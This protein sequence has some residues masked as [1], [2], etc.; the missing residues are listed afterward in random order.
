MNETVTGAAAMALSLRPDLIGRDEADAQLLATSSDSS[1]VFARAAD[2]T[3]MVMRLDDV[4]TRAVLHDV[5]GWIARRVDFQAHVDSDRRLA[6]EPFPIPVPRIRAAD[7]SRRT[8]EYD[9]PGGIRLGDLLGRGGELAALGIDAE[10]VAADLLDRTLEAIFERKLFI[11]TLHPADL[12]ITGCDQVALGVPVVVAGIDETIAGYALRIY[13]AVRDGS[14][15]RAAS[16]I[17]D[18]LEGDDASN[19]ADFRRELTALL[20]A[21]IAGDTASEVA[22]S[23]FVV[24]ETI[25]EVLRLARRHGLSL[26]RLTLGVVLNILTV[27]RIARLLGAKTSLLDIGRDFFEELLL[28]RAAGLLGSDLTGAAADMLALARNLPGDL[29]SILTD[30]ADERFR[31][32]VVTTDSAE[33]RELKN[34]RSRM[35]AVAVITAALLLLVAIPATPSAVRIAF[36]VLLA[37]TAT[38]LVA[39]WWR[40]R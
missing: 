5:R 23:A 21:V 28:R 38:W 33:D 18:L 6:R 17:A 8:I 19:A 20:R 3:A 30:V 14:S 40:L 39:S 26:P 1:R 22:R 31:L 7:A 36:A 32:H 12:V 25:I 27:E 34:L 35:V 13:R 16:A 2:G 10:R 15:N 4:E 11:E 37:A 9:D 29:L 24:G